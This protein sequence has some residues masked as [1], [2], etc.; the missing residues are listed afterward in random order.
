MNM[1]ARRLLLSFVIA[2]WLA[3]LLFAFEARWN[4]GATYY[5][6]L[7]TRSAALPLLTRYLAL[8]VLAHGEAPVTFTFIHAAFWLALF[9]PPLIAGVAVWRAKT[10][11]ELLQLWSYGATSYGVMFVVS[12]ASLVF[13]M[14]LPYQSW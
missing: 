4:V 2:T 1:L 3:F 9:L 10:R 14:W 11:D 6:S 5:N 7:Q 12:V 8:P 13:S